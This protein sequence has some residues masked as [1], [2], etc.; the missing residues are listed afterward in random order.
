[1]TSVGYEAVRNNPEGAGVK[2]LSCGVVRLF[3]RDRQSFL[4]GQVTNDIARLA[5]GQGAHA[6]L[7]NST[8]HMLADLRVYAFPDHLLLETDAER[9]QPVIDI[10]DRYLVREKVQMENLSDQ[11][12][13]VVVEGKGAI[14]A[15]RSLTQT[16][17]IF[18]EPYAHVT[19]K[20][21]LGDVDSFVVAR[22]RTTGAEGYDLWL[23]KEYAAA[24]V[25]RLLDAPGAAAL[26][27]NTMDLLR[28]EGGIPAWG[29]DLDEGIIPVE[30]GME[31]AISY[32]K[33][34]YTG[35]EIIARIRARGHTNRS[36]RGLLLSS[37]VDAGEK[38][39]AV[40]GARA[41]HEIGRVTSFAV[42]PALGPIA[43]GYVRN[44]Y[45]AAGTSLTAGDTTATVTDLPFIGTPA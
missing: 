11:W 3:G 26:D 21:L 24:A 20:T 32:A 29:A 39:F 27:D 25:A 23:P 16:P 37:A 35:Q 6:C 28:I 10:L 1:M 18:K 36:L 2:E 22:T 8:G 34:C 13:I 38:L 14:T 19:V 41:G 33:G 12:R 15:L 44:E 40:D 17:L 7:L 31:D 4:Q 42:S 30:A 45:A 5:P 43:L 9:A